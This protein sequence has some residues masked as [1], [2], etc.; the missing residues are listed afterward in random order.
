MIFRDLIYRGFWVTR[1][2]EAHPEEKEKTVRAVLDLMRDQ[3]LQISMLNK[4]VW[5]WFTPK[6][7]LIHTID[8]TFN[9]NRKGKGMFV[10]EHDYS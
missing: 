4:V 5:E 3:T 1:W 7:T 2:S 10:F 9:S 8:E 6:E